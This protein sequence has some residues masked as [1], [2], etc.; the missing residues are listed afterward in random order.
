MSMFTLAISC[1]I[2]SN[3]PWFLDLTFQVPMQYCSLEHQSLLPSPVTS[4]TGCCFCFG[5]VASFFLELFI[6][7]SPVVNWAPTNLGS[8]FFSVLY[9]CVFILFKGLSRQEYWS[10]LSFPSP[11]TMFFLFTSR[12]IEGETMET[13]TDFILGGS[14]ITVDGDCSHEIKRHL[15]L[16]R[17]IWSN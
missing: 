5:S 13:V 2:T 4:R 10:G 11:G 1:L 3:L 9:F 6:H 7:W 15:F 12:Q 14:K 16:G 17:K 8:S